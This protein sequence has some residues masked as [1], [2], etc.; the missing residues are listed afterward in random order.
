V[1]R[2]FHGA[3]L[4]A[5]FPLVIERSALRIKVGGRLRAFKGCALGERVAGRAEVGLAV[6][7]ICTDGPPGE[8]FALARLEGKALD[9]L[10]TRERKR[11]RE[12]YRQLDRIGSD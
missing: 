8:G 11:W 10:M 6:C 3:N 4:K 2:L 12:L 9:E 7:V 5:R 1:P